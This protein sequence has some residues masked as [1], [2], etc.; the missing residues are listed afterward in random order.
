MTVNT[1][2]QHIHVYRHIYA[3]KR[4]KFL[5]SSSFQLRVHT[6]VY[7]HHASV[8]DSGLHPSKAASSLFMLR[9]MYGR[10]EGLHSSVFSIICSMCATICNTI[11]THT[12]VCVYIPFKQPV[13]YQTID[14]STQELSHEQP[15]KE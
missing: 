6:T 15:K 5:F 10:N 11:N 12:C 8:R 1:Y 7:M 13:M 2:T 4:L 14:M 9:P 3:V